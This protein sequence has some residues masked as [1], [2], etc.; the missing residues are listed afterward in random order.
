MDNLNICFVTTEVYPY[1]KTG[2]LADV[3]SSLPLAMKEMEHD[4]RL[5][6][7]KYRGI[8]ERK[9]TLR[10]VIRLKEIPVEMG[11]HKFLF[12]AKT[13]FL[14]DSKVHIYFL[15]EDSL[16]S[17]AGLYVDPKTG[18]DYE[19]NLERFAAFSKAVLET[20][21][22][23]HWSPNI[24]HCNDWQSAL[25]PVYLKFKYHDDE[26]FSKTKTVLTIHN[27]AYQG[28]YPMKFREVLDLPDELFEKDGLLEWY[29][30][31]NLLKGGILAA[32]Y[33]T[34][35]SP[36]YASEIANDPD[37]GY[38]LETILKN[39]ENQ[40]RGI[41][42]GADYSIWNPEIDS[43]I[44]VRYNANNLHLKKENKKILC[45]YC[46]FEY[47]EDTPLFGMITRLDYQKGVNL[48][49]EQFEELM[50]QDMQLVILGAGDPKLANQLHELQSKYKDKFYFE[51]K[52]NDR[53][54]H[55]IEAG[56]DIFLMPSRYEPCGLNQIYSMKYGTL[57]LVRKTGGL[58]DT[59]IDVLEDEENG[60]GF[61]FHEFDSK[62]LLNSIKVAIQ[63]YK[64]HSDQWKK[65]QLN[66]M[67]KDYSWS[68]SADE[69][70]NVYYNLME[71]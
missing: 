62:A 18:K 17:R 60:T 32:D 11:K 52:L 4:I 40:L 6:V 14:M 66:G 71:Q 20:L 23:L 36:T 38:G 8:S 47:S 29:D 48:L 53:L 12:S 59:V 64:E 45:R 15:Q 31:I 51:F 65:W 24:I 67:E 13:S 28:T 41:L 46:N 7:P 49:I 33:L 43:L 55:L 22:I 27:L 30:G 50:K 2:G 26:F 9:Y 63:K 1:A 42:N 70:L 5:M 56:A 39:R 58:A 3:S 34:T 35:V 19:D 44:P 16:F 54:A 61:V 57:P 21:K 68:R 25:I 10:E 37:Y 69:Y